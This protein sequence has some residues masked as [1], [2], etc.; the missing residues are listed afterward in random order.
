MDWQI[1]FPKELDISTIK[2]AWQT[3]PVLYQCMLLWENNEPTLYYIAKIYYVHD[4]TEVYPDG[5]A[6]KVYWQVEL[7]KSD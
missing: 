1:C 3:D 5:S 6:T 2:F 7:S 4:P